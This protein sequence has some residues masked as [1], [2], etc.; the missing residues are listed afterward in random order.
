LTRYLE[1]PPEVKER[2][3]GPIKRAADAFDVK[4]GSSFLS[5]PKTALTSDG[6]AVPP[7]PKKINKKVD[8]FRR[9]G[10][11]DVRLGDIF[12]TSGE[13]VSSSAPFGSQNVF[14]GEGR[15][16]G[17]GGESS[18]P[19]PKE[20]ES[21]T[22]KNGP[23]RPGVSN[24]ASAGKN[25]M[26]LADQEKLRRE[27]E[28]EKMDVDADEDSEPRVEPAPAAMEVDEDEEPPTED[29]E[30]PTEDEE[31]DSTVPDSVGQKDPVDDF[32]KILKARG[33]SPK[34]ITDS[35]K[36]AQGLVALSFSTVKYKTAV[37]TLLLAKKASTDVRLLLI[38]TG[39]QLSPYNFGR[40]GLAHQS[41]QHRDP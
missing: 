4:I 12:S 23:P 33:A 32:N 40:A 37:E 29:E 7:K 30:P 26:S 19:P 1:P 20:K 15:T 25:R 5:R 17:G 13:K 38:S 18:K 9:E 22:T 24:R 36:V 28:R 31:E 8:N 11:T 10:E 34:L 21:T 2:A 41:L 27:A 14:A 35:I 16:L 39:T 3:A 6:E